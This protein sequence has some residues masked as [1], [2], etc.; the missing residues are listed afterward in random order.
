MG[1]HTVAQTGKLLNRFFVLPAD[2]CTRCISTGHN[3]KRRHPDSII[4]GKEQKL[5]RCIRQHY[6]NLWITRCNTFA[7]CFFTIFFFVQKQDWFLMSGQNFFLFFTDQA[8][9]F[10]RFQ[11]FCHNC[12]WFR[13]TFFQFSEALHR[14][15]ISR[16]TAQVE[17][18]NPLNRHNSA[19]CNGPSGVNDCVSSAFF[20]ADQVDLRTTL[21]TTDWLCIVSPGCR[22]IIFFCAIRTHRKFFH[23]G[24]LPVIRKG[25]QDRKSWPTAGTVDKWMQISTVLR[26]KH[27]FLAFITNCNI[28]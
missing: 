8:F 13:R 21:V 11:I 10:H 16:I 18:S 15:F 20:S 2:R 6:S 3:Q 24:A 22:I 26:I 7:K 23:A 27:F 19:F 1:K 28:R 17:T 25:I 4:I 9:S 5:Y 14:L 12:K